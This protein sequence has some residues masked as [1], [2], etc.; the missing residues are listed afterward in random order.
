[1]LLFRLLLYTSGIFQKL[2]KDQFKYK[3]LSYKIDKASNKLLYTCMHLKTLNKFFLSN[4]K[5][6][7]QENY[8]KSSK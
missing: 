5:V 1:M 7:N 8:A 3:D 4:Y 6:I 2:E